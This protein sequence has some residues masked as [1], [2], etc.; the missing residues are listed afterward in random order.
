MCAYYGI[1]TVPNIDS[2]P[3]WNPHTER[4]DH[5]LITLPMTPQGKLVLVPKII[6]RHRLFYERKSITGTIFFLKC[7]KKSSEQNRV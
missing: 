4:W 5:Q 2:G 6:V 7:S 1:P 3:I